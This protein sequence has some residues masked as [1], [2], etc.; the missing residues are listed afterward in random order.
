[1]KQ[2][3]MLTQ[4]ALPP[5]QAEALYETISD[6]AVQSRTYVGDAA[7]WPGEDWEDDAEAAF[8]R[9]VQRPLSSGSYPRSTP[10]SAARY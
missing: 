4:S 10:K 6:S 8:S 3:L 1:M 9:R 5:A 7:A 2:P